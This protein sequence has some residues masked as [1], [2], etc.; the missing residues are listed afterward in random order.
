[1]IGPGVLG[2]GV[3]RVPKGHIAMVITYLEMTARPAPRTAPVPDGYALA[4]WPDPPLDDYRAIM[5]LIGTDWLWHGRLSLSDGELARRIHG[6]DVDIMC[7]W[8]S[9]SPVAIA[10][11]KFKGDSC[12][13]AFF[14]VAPALIGTTGARALMADAIARAWARPISR[15]DLNTCTLDSPKALDFYRRS[16]FCEYDRAVEV[17]R[18]PRLNGI[19]PRDAAP[20]I[21]V[22]E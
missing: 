1:M 16:G 21:A 9:T 10:E 12:N 17:V 15:F 20:N 8:E 6:P 11:L 19:L 3:H 13:L 18:D 5:R 2:A 22:I 7:L 14:G 4:P